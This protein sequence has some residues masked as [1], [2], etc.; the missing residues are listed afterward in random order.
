MD[1]SETERAVAAG[2]ATAVSLG[3]TANDAVVLH[4]SNRLAVHLRP[5][6]VLAR[7]APKSHQPG[8]VFEVEVARRL[9]ETNGPVAGLDPRVE[10]QVYLQDDFSITLWTYYESVPPQD[11]APPE[12]AGALMRLHE[13]MRQIDMT[14]PH[15]T[16]RIA[17]AQ[18]LVDNRAETPELGD[19]DRELLSSALR[20][21]RHTITIRGADEQLLHGE[22]HPGNLLRTK[23]GL[24]FV[25]LETCCRGPVEFDIAHAPDDVGD[26]YPGID[27]VLVRECRIL[28]QAM[29]TTWRWQPED[30]LPNRDHW[31]LEGLKQLRETIPP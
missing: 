3:M 29:V 27:Q 23:E 1:V 19:D 22:P 13:C 6:D 5:C 20:T 18:G 31:R 30:Q 7:V 10:P 4:N 24:L 11:I 26:H 12:Y 16:N 2:I 25:D 9:A 21:L 14:S 8:Y 17:E 28:M 15:F